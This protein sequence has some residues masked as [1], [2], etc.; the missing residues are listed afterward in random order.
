MTNTY[1]IIVI[2]MYEIYEIYIV[3][4]LTHSSMDWFDISL[5][6]SVIHDAFVGLL[7]AVLLVLV[8]PFRS[9]DAI[10]V[11]T[12]LSISCRMCILFSILVSVCV[13]P[14]SRG[15]VMEFR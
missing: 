6:L 12:L 4:Q 3:L 5:S 7:W 11:P 2:Q 10:L 1:W 13:L 15:G 9:S 14:C 8:C